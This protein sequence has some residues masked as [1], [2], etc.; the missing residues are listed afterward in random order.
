[1]QEPI[2]ELLVAVMGPTWI[3]ASAK[4][5]LSPVLTCDRGTNR[6]IEL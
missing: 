1:M 5:S 4:N 6:P 2:H 3:F